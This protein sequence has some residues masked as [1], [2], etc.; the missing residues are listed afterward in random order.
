MPIFHSQGG[1]SMLVLCGIKDAR[2][3]VEMPDGTRGEVVVVEVRPNK[4]VRIGFEFPQSVKVDRKVIR[5]SKD[6][7][8]QA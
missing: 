3:V 4:Q 7:G 2:F 5:E 8:G 1:I 6:K